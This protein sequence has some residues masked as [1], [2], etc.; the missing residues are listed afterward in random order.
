MTKTD[1][2][3]AG[4]LEREL[5]QHIQSF[6]RN[7]LGHTPSKVSC[8]LVKNKLVVVAENSI[9]PAEQVLDKAGKKEL[10]QKLRINLNKSIKLQLKLLIEDISQLEVV[11]LLGETQLDS[12]LTGLIIIFNDVPN[13]RSRYGA[14]KLQGNGTKK[15]VNRLDKVQ[16]VST[17]SNC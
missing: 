4:Q 16:D 17:T 7:R 13:L 9:T 6:Y 15:E 11:D 2:L 8:H 12:G 10:A 3:T 5:S 1:V 14:S